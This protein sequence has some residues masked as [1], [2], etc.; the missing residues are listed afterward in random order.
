MK[1]CSRQAGNELQ[2][3]FEH[4]FHLQHHIFY[5]R[6]LSVLLTFIL[7]INLL[8]YNLNT[9]YL[10]TRQF[11]PIKIQSGFLLYNILVLMQPVEQIFLVYTKLHS[12]FISFLDSQNINLTQG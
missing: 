2:V 12:Q 8:L 11:T 3:F 4:T 10:A 5:P 7:K 6:K 9:T 1:N